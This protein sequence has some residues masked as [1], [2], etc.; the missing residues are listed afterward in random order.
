MKGTEKINP[1]RPRYNTTWDPARVI[2]HFKTKEQNEDLSLKEL[3]KKLVTLLALATGQRMQTISLIKLQ[4]I[5]NL[6]DRIK[7][8]I[9]D[10]IK[11][12]RK[13]AL[14]PCLDLPF[15]NEEPKVCVAS[16]LEVYIKTTA[17][18]RETDENSL[19]LTYKKP[20]KKATQT[21]LS[22]WVRETLEEARVDP[23][24]KAHSTRHASTSK[25]LS[26]GVPL[27]EILSTAGWSSQNTFSRFYHRRCV[28]STF[29]KSILLS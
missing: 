2:D 28:D 19:F 21:T 3:S 9:P 18:L 7:I 6:G 27:D 26:F 10:K 8:Y 12:T 5:C 4:N 15:L 29:A 25:A 16:L 24:F 23:C 22:R 1:S 17:T 14:Q 20:Y 13:N 11:T